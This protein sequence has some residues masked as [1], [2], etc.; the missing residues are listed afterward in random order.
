MNRKR[1]HDPLELGGE[2]LHGRRLTRDT[3]KSTNATGRG[4]RN[5]C[6]VCHRESAK[7]TN[8]RRRKGTARA[9]GPKLVVGGTC[10]NGHMLTEDTLR[11]R[12]ATGNQARHRICLVC[13]RESM[14]R[15]RKKQK[16]QREWEQEN[17]RVVRSSFREYPG[18]VF[19]ITCPTCGEEGPRVLRF[20][21]RSR[22]VWVWRFHKSHEKRVSV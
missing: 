8:Q 22:A 14:R 12:K 18:G 6:A 19:V 5:Y 7:R 1:Y 10:K 2:C 20:R 9:V 13:R 4:R 11:I 16:E 15:H 3:L 17:I 21:D